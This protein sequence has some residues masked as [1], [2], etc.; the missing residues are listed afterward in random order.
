MVFDFV[1]VVYT[2][3]V[4]A[5]DVGNVLFLQLQT[6]RF[7]GPAEQAQADGRMLVGGSR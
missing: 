2:Q 5:G 1:S 6:N 7:G 4:M 3:A